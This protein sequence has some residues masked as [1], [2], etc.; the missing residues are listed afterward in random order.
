M[1]IVIIVRHRCRESCRLILVLCGRENCDFSEGEM[2]F[3]S[4]LSRK[5]ILV[6]EVQYLHGRERCDINEAQLYYF[7]FYITFILFILFKIS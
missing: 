6:C 1:N 7:I 5:S 3:G 2:D 4:R